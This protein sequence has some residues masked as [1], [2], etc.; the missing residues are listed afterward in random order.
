MMH[1]PQCGLVVDGM[2]GKT[3]LIFPFAAYEAKS[4]TDTYNAA[5]RQIK[6]ACRIYLAMLDDLARNPNNV[7]E[8]QTKESSG[9]QFFAFTSNYSLW[10]VFVAWGS[11]DVCMVDTIWGGDIDKPSDALQLLCIVDQIHDYAI[12]HHLPFVLKHLEAWCARDSQSRLPN[13]ALATPGGSPLWAILKEESKIVKQTKSQETRK[14][15][16]ESL[17]QSS[18]SNQT[19][20]KRRRV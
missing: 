6:H 19:Q 15:N 9:F 5:E 7:S 18:D 14:R 8:Y 10:R 13:N 11:L 1:N 20:T 17:G 16:R 12:K 3:A 4:R 2:W